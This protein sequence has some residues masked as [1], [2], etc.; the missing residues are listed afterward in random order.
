MK[1]APTS[2]V[3]VGGTREIGAMLFGERAS[4]VYRVPDDPHVKAALTINDAAAIAGAKV[5]P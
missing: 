1:A 4:I 3:L 5:N 2:R